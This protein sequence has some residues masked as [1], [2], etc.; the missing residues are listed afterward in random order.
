MRRGGLE[1]HLG[2]LSCPSSSMWSLLGK[3]AEVSEMGS[4]PTYGGQELWRRLGSY[5]MRGLNSEM[6]AGTL[7]SLN[8]ETLASVW[9]VPFTLFAFLLRPLSPETLPG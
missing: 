7:E 4:R 8:L 5:L 2:D 6:S 9:G 3:E 1:I